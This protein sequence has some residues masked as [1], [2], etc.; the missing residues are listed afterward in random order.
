[1][2]M[3]DQKDFAAAVLDPAR[4]VPEGLVTPDG[5]P[6]QRRFDV[7]R[8]N[9]VYSLAEALKT[10]FPAIHSL[11]GEENFK[12]LAGL[13][14]RRH[15]PR[16]PVLMLYGED[17]PGF[18]EDL[19]QV[20]HLPYLPDV[21]RLELARR[22][23]YH[24]SDAPVLDPAALAIE[25]EALMTA[26]LVVHPALRVI[27]SHYPVADIWQFAMDPS[28]PKPGAAGQA[29]AVTRPE[30][31]PVQTVLPPG[32]ATFLAS[33][34]DGKRFGE[35]VD[36]AEGVPGFGLSDTLSACLGAGAF[37]TLRS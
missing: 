4:P 29:V 26:E 8:N 13:F 25:A 31:D 14:V 19:P 1:M 36:A 20:A 15:P 12:G 30:F 37:T 6:A 35:A 7:Y 32:A 17:L 22:Q 16:S 9:V 24:A 27:R 28:S 10:A 11:L 5:Q 21:A 23:A 3:P 2:A 33:L 18:L 34:S